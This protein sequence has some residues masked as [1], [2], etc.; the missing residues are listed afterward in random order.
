LPWPSSS[1][2]AIQGPAYALID[3]STKNARFLGDVYLGL[4]EE[5]VSKVEPIKYK[6]ADGLE[7]T[8]YLTLPRD[9]LG[10]DWPT[11]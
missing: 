11:P 7:I 3:L 2:P 10:F 8:G 6:A 5:G 1:A 4:T 9:T